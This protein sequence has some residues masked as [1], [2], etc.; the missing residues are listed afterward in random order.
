MESLNAGVEGITLDPV[1]DVMR[2]TFIELEKV[3]KN[4]APNT[5]AL[6]ADLMGLSDED[7]TTVIN[8]IPELGVIKN[9]DRN[10]IEKILTKNMTDGDGNQ[11][12][13]GTKL[14]VAGL[15]LDAGL[16]EDQVTQYMDNFGVFT[17]DRIEKFLDTVKGKV[18]PTA[19]ATLATGLYD[20]FTSDANAQKFINNI[21]Q[22][23][24]STK[25]LMDLMKKYQEEGLTA[26]ESASVFEKLQ[27]PELLA[28]F[29]DGTLTA[30]EFM[31]TQ[32]DTY[33]EKVQDALDAI[34][35]EIKMN[36]LTDE[37]AREQLIYTELLNNIDD[38]VLGT[39]DAMNEYYQSQIDYIK[40]MNAELQQEIDLE[41]QRLD[42]NRSMLSLN[43][44]IMALERD[45]SYG[46]QA[47]LEDLRLTREQEA[48]QRQKYIMDTIATQQI[49]E[50]E[51][52]IQQNI[53]SA[54]ARTAY[55]TEVMAGILA[56]GGANDTILATTG[57]S[58]GRGGTGATGK[59]LATME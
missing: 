40:E 12:G 9:F 55:Y 17:I 49:A 51:S 4:E 37:L 31:G 16:A 34:Q 30:T 36:G 35:S 1:T 52:K 33:K 15:M 45:T 41:Q 18:D 57:V 43:R 58:I 13:V 48:V 53:A 21:E 23:R 8:A 32:L 28:K 6:M 56:G 3:V 26:E 24:T 50:L 39:S 27:D 29:Y 20:S 47:Q 11:I 14:S 2:N 46:A 19:F 44:Q 59:T 22:M 7:F 5:A 38:L 10:N 25:G 54:T 42:M